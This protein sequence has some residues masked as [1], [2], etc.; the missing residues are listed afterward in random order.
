LTAKYVAALATVAVLSLTGQVLVQAILD[1]HAADSRVINLA[2]RQRMLSQQLVKTALVSVRAEP[3]SAAAPGLPELFAEWTRV[4][5]GLRFGDHERGLPGHNSQEV[6]AAFARLET[7]FQA[8]RLAL[9]DI[10]DGLTDGLA[11][12]RPLALV[13]AIARLLDHESAFLHGMDEI[14]SL[15]ERESSARVRSLQRVEIT[16]LCLVLLTLLLEG[17]FVFRPVVKRIRATV[18]RLEGDIAERRQLEKEL[19]VV[20]E[21]EQTR[22]GM[23]LHDGLCQ[24]LAGLSI[25]TRTLANQMA[26]GKLSEPKEIEPELSSL[27]RLTQEGLAMARQIARGLFP[28]VLMEKGLAAALE[29]ACAMAESLYKQVACPCEVDIDGIAIDQ[30]T[31]FQIFRIAQ[32]ALGN[33]IRHGK[34]DKVELSLVALAGRELVLRIVD[35]GVGLPEDRT[36]ATSPGIGLRSISTRART[37]GA[38]LTIEAAQPTGTIVECRLVL[39]ATAADLA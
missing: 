33:A 20:A 10:T 5:R 23:D 18:A 3:Q 38:A 35:N 6:E 34:A 37:I 11:P 31:A 9:D 29:Q 26:Q 15:Y 32:E 16:L 39:N 19:L 25:M 7:S 2:G 30:D 8:M 1:T 27:A 12:G 36:P 21:R 17:W 14:V 4:H 13:P 28:E 24:H 22:I